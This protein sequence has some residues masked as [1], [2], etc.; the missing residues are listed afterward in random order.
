MEAIDRL[1]EIFNA[2]LAA[3]RGTAPVDL[4]TLTAEEW[5]AFDQRMVDVWNEE[6]FRLAKVLRAERRMIRVRMRAESPMDW[7]RYRREMRWKH[8]RRVW[9]EMEWVSDDQPWS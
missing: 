7:L 8:R 1:K 2:A 5:V 9:L 4:P 6:P 3:Q